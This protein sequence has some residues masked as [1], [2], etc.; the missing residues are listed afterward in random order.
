MTMQPNRMHRRFALLSFSAVLGIAA[1]ASCSSG[2]PV[3]GGGRIEHAG[4]RIPV[5]VPSVDAGQIASPSATMGPLSP[6]DWAIRDDCPPR[7][8]SKDVPARACTEDSE[9]GDGYCDRD[10]CSAIWTCSQHYGQRCYGPRSERSGLCSGLCLEGRCRTCLSDDECVRELGSRGAV[11]NRYP[12]TSGGRAC[13][14]LF[15]KPPNI[16]PGRIPPDA[17]DEP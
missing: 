11:C 10:H 1:M 9:C 17:G 5:P 3:P 2:K 13:V 6:L 8:W 7:P 15:D 14:I 4:N 12:D 16:T